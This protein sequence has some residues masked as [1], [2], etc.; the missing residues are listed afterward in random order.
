LNALLRILS[1]SR[2]NR[3]KLSRIDVELKVNPL[4]L[5]QAQ[6]P[7]ISRRHDLEHSAT[8]NILIVRQQRNKIKVGRNASQHQ[9]EPTVSLPLLRQLVLD[10]S[11]PNRIILGWR[12]L[13][14]QFMLE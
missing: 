10:L 7:S 1:S 11:Y 8:R 9:L 12:N 14:N 2:S 13:R 5:L 6:L 3:K 4:L